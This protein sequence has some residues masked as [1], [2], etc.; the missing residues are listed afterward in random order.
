[1]SSMFYFRREARAPLLQYPFKEE[2]PTEL[3]ALEGTLNHALERIIGYVAYS[4]RYFTGILQETGSAVTNMINYETTLGRIVEDAES[5]F[6]NS[7]LSEIF[8]GRT[9]GERIALLNYVL[10]HEHIRIYGTGN[11]RRNIG[12]FL[13]MQNLKYDC[14]VVTY[15]YEK[16]ESCCN[17]DLKYL[18]EL[19]TASIIV[20][21]DVKYINDV[22]SN[23][24]STTE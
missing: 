12:S 3:I 23:W 21:L 13:D 17:H 9:Y 6:G 18:S 19:G 14:F 8:S 5:S 7:L 16:A 10:T 15:G 22:K 20:A 24:Q 1:M 11:N 4:Q 2:F